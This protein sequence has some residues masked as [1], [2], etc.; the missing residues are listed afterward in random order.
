VAEGRITAFEM[1]LKGVDEGRGE[2]GEAM[3][4][5]RVREGREDAQR[6]FTEILQVNI[7][8]ECTLL[9]ISNWFYQVGH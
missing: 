8:I 2:V 5:M 9:R 1:L 7:N 4:Q 6:N 3:F